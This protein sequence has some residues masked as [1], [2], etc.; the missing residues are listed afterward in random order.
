MSVFF[1]IMKNETLIKETIEVAIIRSFEAYLENSIPDVI[2]DTTF[3]S[4]L[5]LY[6]P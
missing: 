2:K 6:S 5:N 1:Q 4:A 3:S